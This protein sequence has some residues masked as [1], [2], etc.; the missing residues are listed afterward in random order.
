MKV[1][2]RVRTSEIETHS[3]RICGLPLFYFSN[4]IT[5]TLSNLLKK[6]AAKAAL[7]SM[8]KREWK[9]TPVYIHHPWIIPSPSKLGED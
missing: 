9:T 6:R 4:R 1:E 8:S 5:V 3:C 7:S 2:G